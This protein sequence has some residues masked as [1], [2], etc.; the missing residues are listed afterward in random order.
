MCIT[1]PMNK[2]LSLLGIVA[3]ENTATYGGE[4]RSS[5]LQPECCCLARPAGCLP[6]S[7]HCQ[8]ATLHRPT[9]NARTAAA[10]AHV[11]VCTHTSPVT[12][13]HLPPG[14][15]FLEAAHCLG[16]PGTPSGCT[17]TMESSVFE[18]N[19]ASYGGAMYVD[20]STASPAQKAC[21][22]TLTNVSFADNTASA[23]GTVAYLTGYASAESQTKCCLNSVFR[24]AAELARWMLG[25]SYICSSRCCGKL[26]AAF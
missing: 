13:C 14:A 25:G 12:S 11:H 24:W 16:T 1:T 23:E 18:A 4:Q 21:P 17:T 10:T 20:T 5:H 3:R 2:T 9:P 8:C 26:P 7:R 15:I 19:N 6:A 22:T